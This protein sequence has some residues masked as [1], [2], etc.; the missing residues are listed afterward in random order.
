MEYSYWHINIQNNRVLNFFDDVFR[1]I[2]AAFFMTSPVSGLLIIS[3]LMLFSFTAAALGIYATLIAV[4]T[5][6][7]LQRDP[8]LMKIGF[9]GFN[10]TLTGL[11][12]GFL[13]P[14]TWKSVAVL[15]IAVILT[16]PIMILLNKLLCLGRYNLPPLS[17][18]SL[19]VTFPSIEIM[20]RFNISWPPTNLAPQGFDQIFNSEYMFAI[21]S[22]T[23]SV[24]VKDLVVYALVL[25][26]IAI[27]SR[28]L[29]SS[30]IKGVLFG[31]I[32]AYILGGTNGFTWNRLYIMNIAAIVVA[33]DGF[34]LAPGTATRIYTFLWTVIGTALWVGSVNIGLKL[35]LP[36]YTLPFVISTEAALFLAHQKWVQAIFK[37][38]KPV[39]LV[40][41]NTPET[42]ETW[43][44]DLELAEYYWQIVAPGEQPN[45]WEGDM[46][47][48]IDKAVDLILKSKSIVAFT[49][50]GIST[51]SN[52]P[53]YRTG[54]V[55]WKKY[56]TKHF[57][58]EA[59]NLSEESRAKYW[60]MSQDFYQLIKQARP[61]QA[62]MAFVELEK[63]GKLK[64]IIT[65]NV[66]RLH[67]KAGVSAEKVLE[68]HGNELFVTCLNCGRKYTREE[69]YEWI[70]NGVKVPYCLQCQGLLKPDS[71][72]FGQ[73]MP[74]HISQHAWDMVMNCDLMIIMGTSLLVQPAALLPWKAVENGAKLMIINLTSTV[75]DEHADV[76]IRAGTGKTM[77]KILNRIDTVKYYVQ[78][79]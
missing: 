4:I 46:K 40:Y 16:V 33:L 10:G 49:G 70:L 72:A 78:L 74:L 45:N 23:A 1:A 21:G 29:L 12:W 48:R 6:K 22:I 15:T 28:R 34:F 31:L 60:E 30:A 79:P 42:S 56:D 24:T 17:T 66:D 7:L 51:E 35:G 62:H 32:A 37:G 59:F 11:Y 19:L 18:A 52:I 65:Q 55:H 53:D 44:K 38:L 14:L 41:V 73:P 75:Y 54:T 69:I 64:G 77:Q 25:F 76:L 20:R 58:W 26:G 47:S 39:P 8:N 9:F 67:Q 63:M 61:N 5:A 71:I 57:R 36:E 43:I 50:A 2:G 13:G 3:G 27:H 68:I